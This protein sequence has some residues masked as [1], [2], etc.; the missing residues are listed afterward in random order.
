MIEDIADDVIPTWNVAVSVISRD[1]YECQIVN[2]CNQS[3]FAA[4]RY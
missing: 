4:H 2:N 3:I 1:Q